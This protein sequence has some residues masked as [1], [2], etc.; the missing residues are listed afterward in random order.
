MKSN[1]TETLIG[2]FIVIDI[3]IMNT[4]D[5][6]FSKIIII[7]T[8]AKCVPAFQ[9]SRDLGRMFHVICRVA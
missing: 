7:S 8:I 3:Y 9:S 6:W 1:E 5:L 2:Y 4:N